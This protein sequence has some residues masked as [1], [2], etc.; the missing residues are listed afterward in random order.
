MKKT[1]W[2]ALLTIVACVVVGTA[3][4]HADRAQ[5]DRHHEQAT[6]YYRVEAYEDAIEEWKASYELHPNPSRLFN[7]GRAYEELGDAES[8]IEHYRR[9]V[10]DDPD[11]GAITEANARIRGLE[12]EIESARAERE[13]RDAV[14]SARGRMAE[15]DYDGAVEAYERAYELSNDPSIIYEI[16]QAHRLAG[17]HAR[18]ISEY[19]RYVKLAPDGDRAAD[20]LAHQ[21]TLEAE[22]EARGDDLDSETDPDTEADIHQDASGS[23]GWSGMRIAG[24]GSL[25][26]VT[27]GMGAGVVFGLQARSAQSNVEGAEGSWSRDLDDEVAKGEAA[28][29]NLIVAT[30]VSGAALA[31]GGVLLYLDGQSGDEG[32]GG[33]ISIAP[34]LTES[35]AGLAVGG[36]F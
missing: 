29:R 20:A 28:Q 35:S 27:V 24:V 34:S 36:R 3:S 11:G 18:A 6:A 26:V 19:E 17:E 16:A 7:I 23:G 2:I 5:A 4:A 14:V 33:R 8:A 1:L 21:Q 30:V 9:Y 32:S 13:L 31:A 15:R 10:A 22:I 25:G 12:R